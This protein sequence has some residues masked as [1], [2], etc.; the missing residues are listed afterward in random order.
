MLTYDRIIFNYDTE[1]KSIVLGIFILLFFFGFR[2]FQRFDSKMLPVWIVIFVI[3]YGTIVGFLLNKPINAFNDGSSYFPL[4]LIFLI[5]SLKFKNNNRDLIFNFIKVLLIILTIKFIVNQIISILL[6]GT[7]SWKVLFKQTPVLLIGY[8]I[9]INSYFAKN[10]IKTVLLIFITLFLLVVGMARMIFVCLI[11]ITIFQLFLNFNKHVF[12]KLFFLVTIFII[13]FLTYF[14]FQQT[15]QED[16]F[17]NIYGGKNYEDGMDYRSNQFNILLQRFKTYPITG[18]GFGAVTKGYE[19]YEELSKP[20]QLELDLIN[21][22]TKIGIL[23]S[24][25]Y[26]FSYYLLHKL[27]NK[28]HDKMIRKFYYSFE[29]GLISLLIYSLGQTAHQGYIYWVI[30]TLFYSL[31]LIE[32][33]KQYDR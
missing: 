31:L 2:K 1:S 7:P 13:S 16:I 8:S 26:F 4:L 10:S 15:D 24:I 23:I 29:I 28:I 9:L 27:I 12:L 21:F 30:Y 17:S 18:V 5:P 33:K 14:Y 32:I 20:Y 25:L 19:T 22:L 3:S 6:F 11:F